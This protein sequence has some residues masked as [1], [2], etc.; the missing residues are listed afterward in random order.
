M[1]FFLVCRQGDLA[2]P[3]GVTRNQPAAFRPLS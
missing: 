3:Q 1:V 2:S